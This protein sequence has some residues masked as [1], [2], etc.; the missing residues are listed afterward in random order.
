MPAGGLGTAA[1]IGGGLAGVS[2]IGKG[3]ASIF[4]NKSANKID[5]NNLSKPTDVSKT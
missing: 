2:A 1:L 4:Q 3:I 5:K